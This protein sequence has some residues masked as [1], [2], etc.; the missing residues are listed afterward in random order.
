M[1]PELRALVMMFSAPLVMVLLLHSS[2]LCDGPSASRSRDYA[3][4]IQEALES[5]DSL[6]KK[7]HD[8]FTFILPGSHGLL[9]QS[10]TVLD[11]KCKYVG[12]A[13]SFQNVIAQ[14]SY[15]WEG[16]HTTLSVSIMVLPSYDAAKRMMAGDQVLNVLPSVPSVVWNG[17]RIGDLSF[18]RHVRGLKELPLKEITFVRGNLLVKVFIRGGRSPQPPKDAV[19]DLQ[20][21]AATI[22]SYFVED[23][24]ASSGK[25]CA[26]PRPTLDVT[27]KG[28]TAP[29][30]VRMP[31]HANSEEQLVKGRPYSL[32]FP[33]RSGRLAPSELRLRVTHGEVTQDVR[34]RYSVR[35]GETGHQKVSCHHINAKGEC[36]AWGDVTVNVKEAP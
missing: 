8:G 16:E 7:T 1:F 35:F 17:E 28:H 13:G 32:S 4:L 22:D 18:A 12:S 36:T 9:L 27:I 33:T 21:V 6:E 2:V 11:G 29:G 34:G 14:E 10:R 31:G 19:S 30:E 5:Y 26:M 24:L 15:D 3:Q 25:K 20:R 23:P